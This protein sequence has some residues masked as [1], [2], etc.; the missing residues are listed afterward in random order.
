[1]NR[2]LLKF[3]IK[4]FIILGLIV[5]LSLFLLIK[6]FHLS[7]SQ[8]TSIAKGFYIDRIWDKN[9]KIGDLVR[10]TSPET[11]NYK[12]Q[13]LIKRISYFTDDKKAFLTGKSHEQL[14]KELHDERAYSFDSN[15]FGTISIN[16]LTPV[17]LILPLP[18]FISYKTK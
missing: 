15:F 16:E 4:L 13:D 8:T 14:V 11:E 2:N 5:F 17:I 6:V 1:M 3:G 18:K 12:S 9:L 10:F 7:Y